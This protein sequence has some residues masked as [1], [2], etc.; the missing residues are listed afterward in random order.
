[1]LVK[2]R[3]IHGLDVSKLIRSLHTTRREVEHAREY[4]D[5]HVLDKTGYEA[6]DQSQIIDHDRG[7][8]DADQKYEANSIVEPLWH[9]FIIDTL[10]C[11]SDDRQLAG[12]EVKGNCNEK[13]H[14]EYQSKQDRE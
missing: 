14:E 4:E 2:K 1:M 11:D 9:L 6:E 3:L 5:N 8:A 12:K 7:I 13:N 10:T